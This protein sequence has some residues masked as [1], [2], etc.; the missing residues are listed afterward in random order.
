VS[1]VTAGMIKELRAKTGV[2][3]SKCKGALQEA[4]GDMEQA[5]VILRKAGMTSAA[6]KEGREAKE[7]AIG[8]FQEGEAL[9]LVE[10]NAETDFVVNNEIFKDFVSQMAKE[11]ASTRP[12]S[13]EGFAQQK[14]S[15]DQELTIDQYR[16]IIIQKVGE[17]IQLRR[18]AILENKANT[19]LG[20]YSH[21]GG[22]IVAIVEV[23]GSED[24]AV[25]ARD[26]AMHVAAARPQY[27]NPEVVP[28]TV[29]EGELEIAREQVKGKPEHIMDKILDGKIRAFF[30]D[31]CLVRQ[32]YVRDDKKTIQEV[33]DLRAKEIGKSLT[34]SSF[35][36]WKVGE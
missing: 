35:I 34:V 4:Q 8:S 2:G 16:S 24:E 10:V 5:V 17:N 28:E 31:V 21:M 12:E 27:L 25:L 33:V 3:M 1:N 19:S 11:I 22:K 14:F 29:R 15:K 9:A 32:K 13:V 7:G 36:C 26:I 6:K 23:S 18:L 30:D 20:L